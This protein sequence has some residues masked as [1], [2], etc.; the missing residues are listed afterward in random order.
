M[1]Q[2][3][4]C[5][6]TII[7]AALSAQVYS[8]TQTQA[9]LSEGIDNKL[10]G[11]EFRLYPERVFWYE[12]QTPILKA[13]IRNKEPKLY[14]AILAYQYWELSVDDKWYKIETNMIPRKTALPSGRRFPKNSSL[15]SGSWYDDMEIPTSKAWGGSEER[16]K[17]LAQGEHTIRTA[18]YIY[19]ENN[20]HSFNKPV[21]RVI[22]NPVTINVL[23]R[24][25]GSPEH[26]VFFQSHFEMG[27]E[28]PITLRPRNT[29][30]VYRVW[31]KT[32]SFNPKKRIGEKG[33]KK[34]EAKLHI[35]GLDTNNTEWKIRIELLD[36]LGRIIDEVESIQH[37]SGSKRLKIFGG[38]TG[39]KE[40]EVKLE[41]GTQ[42]YLY[43]PSIKKFRVYFQLAQEERLLTHVIDRRGWGKLVAGLQCR[44]LPD[45]Y[46]WK[47]D[48]SHR[49]IIAN[50]RNEGSWPFTIN[51]TEDNCQI[52]VDGQW[53]RRLK[54]NAESA[55][56]PP[57]K[58]YNGVIVTLDDTWRHTK[59]YSKLELTKEKHSLQVAFEAERSSEKPMPSVWVVSN[60]VEIEILA[61]S[62]E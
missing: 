17:T 2:I 37:I 20:E 53:Y 38:G 35:D 61:N 19:S 18:C 56:F 51:P 4:S 55:P 7:C 14:Y 10:P 59:D 13:G 26:G 48:Q 36:Q 57:S 50:I 33:N 30:P 45:K 60:P 32:I 29:I 24:Y 27:K 15:P 44:I 22:S 6:C 3:K 54:H 46:S 31:P 16:L 28:I 58:Q 39:R 34:L 42:N 11:I 43:Y 1:K 12:G 5:L 40:H 8:D 9:A 49:S 62:S 41:L 52:C 21:A 23:P 25:G 47:L